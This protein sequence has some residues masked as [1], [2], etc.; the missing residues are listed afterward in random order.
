MN[1]ISITFTEALGLGSAIVIFFGILILFKIN[2]LRS[3]SKFSAHDF[4]VTIAIGSIFGATVTSK[5]PSIIQGIVAIAS[6]LA[7]QALF[8]KWR[9]MRDVT[10]LENEPLLLTDKSEILYDNLKKS[11]MT[12][13][14]LLSKLR[15]SNV[16]HK[17]SASSYL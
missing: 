17:S 12:K 7:L 15:E 3:F 14:D 6:V 10:F 16:L 2:G 4:A 1:W 13:N 11:D 9:I 5:N 8:S